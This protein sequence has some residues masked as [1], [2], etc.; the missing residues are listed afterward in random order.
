MHAGTTTLSPN[1][2]FLMGWRNV[3]IG[4][5]GDGAKVEGLDVWRHKWRRVD[6]PPV[7]LPHPQYPNQIHEYFI[8]E[9]GDTS[10]PVRFAAGELSYGIWGF[11]V[12][13][14]DIQ[15]GFAPPNKSGKKPD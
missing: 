2:V 7:Q 3:H 11:Y 9:I 13:T 1:E 8:C 10:A 15:M 5:E 14:I 12:P 6:V 4:V